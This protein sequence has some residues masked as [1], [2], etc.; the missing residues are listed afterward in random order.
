MLRYSI[1]QMA[2]E[3]GLTLRAVRFYEEKG[4]LEPSRVSRTASARRIYSDDERFRL[5]EIVNLT[6]MGFTLAEIARGNITEE[7]YRQ[8]LSFCLGRIAELEAAVQ[9]LRER[10]DGPA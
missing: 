9:L 6:K 8:Q 2:D 1:R 10:I 7:Q 3:F 5:A 4:L